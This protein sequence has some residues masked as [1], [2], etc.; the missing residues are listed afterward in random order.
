MKTTARIE[1]NARPTGAAKLNKAQFESLT[2]GEKL[3]VAKSQANRG[4]LSG[5]RAMCDPHGRL[6]DY[7]DAQWL[8]LVE[9][10]FVMSPRR[11]LNGPR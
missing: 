2:D 11:K 1:A 4:A 5:T 10:F 9:A 6:A 8:S 7:D 3:K